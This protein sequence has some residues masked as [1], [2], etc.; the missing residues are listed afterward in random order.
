[1]KALKP[2]IS[3]AVATVAAQINENIVLTQKGNDPFDLLIELS[4]CRNALMRFRAKPPKS[5]Y[6]DPA[7][8]IG[9]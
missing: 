3:K 7:L 9:V 2:E 4:V 8:I 5:E 6:G 1:M